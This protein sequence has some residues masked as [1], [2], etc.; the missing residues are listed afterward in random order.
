MLSS[1]IL[2]T[3][4]CDIERHIGGDWKHE[5]DIYGCSYR[6]LNFVIDGVEYVIILH[7]VEEGHHFTE[8]LTEETER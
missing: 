7:K 6:H 4:A 2:E 8:F 5:V 1:D 3:I